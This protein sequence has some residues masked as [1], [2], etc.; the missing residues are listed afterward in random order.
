M[1]LSVAGGLSDTHGEGGVLGII[2]SG[3]NMD[4]P[5]FA[6]TGSDAYTRSNPN[7]AGVHLGWFDPLIPTTARATPATTS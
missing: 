4:H 7:G 1:L 3:A 2:D 6:A 5:S